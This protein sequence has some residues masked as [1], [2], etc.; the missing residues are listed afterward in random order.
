MDEY[1]EFQA[2][3]NEHMN[4]VGLAAEVS[5][6]GNISLPARDFAINITRG[7]Y[8]KKTLNETKDARK[9][10]F[11]LDIGS[12]K[13]KRDTNLFAEE[14]LEGILS[15]FDFDDLK[16]AVRIAKPRDEYTGR[17]PATYT[18]I[19]KLQREVGKMELT[20][21]NKDFDEIR[22]A[23]REY[24]ENEFSDPDDEEA[25]RV[26]ETFLKMDDE[27][28]S[29]TYQGEYSKAVG[30]FEG[31]LETH[32]TGYLAATLKG[33]DFVDF[34]DHFSRVQERV[35]EAKAQGRG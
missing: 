5:K 32:G 2:R 34:Y 12:K 7:D 28:A 31:K 13:T 6:T 16:T 11:A 17:K 3:F 9:I 23:A 10:H 22:R 26:A 21:Q 27:L 30:E 19:A 15:G 4:Y 20:M 8:P 1:K 18:A 35:A 24:F 33:R 29:I 14:N 25:L